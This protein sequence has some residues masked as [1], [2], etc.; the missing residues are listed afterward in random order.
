MSFP[1]LSI[2]PRSQTRTPI[3]NVI[4]SNAD[5]GGIVQS[6]KRGTKDY[7]TLEIEYPPMGAA[8]Y[9]LLMH[10][11]TG[12]WLT[13]GLFGIFNWTFD[14]VTYAVRFKTPIA[15]TQSAQTGK[16]VGVKFTLEST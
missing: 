4:L 10:P 7:W 1:T 12:F 14:S 5:R 3:E 16:Y 15:G 2:R 9:A 13:V 6:R 11:T 8:D